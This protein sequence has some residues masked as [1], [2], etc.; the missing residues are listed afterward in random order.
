MQVISFITRAM[1]TKGF[2]Q[3]ETAD[4][5]VY[6]NVPGPFVPR[7]GH[8]VDVVTYTKYLGA[9][10]EAG[11]PSGPFADFDRPATR[12]WFALVLW[13]AIKDR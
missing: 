11:A 1:A 12:A 7:Q 10:P 9:V 2:W 3:F 5:G 8:R 13:Q 6:A 4:S